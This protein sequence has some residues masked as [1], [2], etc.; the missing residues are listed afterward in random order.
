MLPAPAKPPP[1]MS[2]YVTVADPVQGAVRHSPPVR[3]PQKM[4]LAIELPL[5]VRNA[6]P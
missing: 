5:L 6:A 4:L 1:W 2:Q 3:S